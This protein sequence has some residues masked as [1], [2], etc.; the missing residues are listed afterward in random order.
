[1]KHRQNFRPVCQAGIAA[2]HRPNPSPS[3]YGFGSTCHRDPVQLLAASTCSPRPAAGQAVPPRILRW[4]QHMLDN[5][6]RQCNLLIWQKT[7]GKI[8]DS[9]V[10]GM[11]RSWKDLV[12]PRAGRREG[13]RS[14]PDSDTDS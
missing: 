4:P 11:V 9:F 10:T 12:C 1:M 13:P 2:V 5:S 8:L 14:S 7:S 3:I 6:M